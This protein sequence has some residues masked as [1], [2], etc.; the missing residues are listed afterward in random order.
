MND[1]AKCVNYLH[2]SVISLMMETLKALLYAKFWSRK[3]KTNGIAFLCHTILLCL[4]AEV[5]HFAR[6]C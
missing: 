5:V 2:S 4:V 1:I 6:R 3:G